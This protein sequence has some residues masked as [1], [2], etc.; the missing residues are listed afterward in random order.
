VW[1]AL[2]YFGTSG[3]ASLIAHDI[4][5]ARRLADLVRETPGFELWEPQG[6]SIVC[7]RAAPP[8]LHCDDA[9]IDALN[10]RVLASLQLSGKAFLSSTVLRGRTWLRSCVVNPGTMPADIDAVFAAVRSYL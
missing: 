5:M 10:Q 4:A 7:F 3:Y 6:L 2:R 8:S 1:M 9:A